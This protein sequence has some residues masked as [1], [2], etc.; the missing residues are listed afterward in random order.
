MKAYGYSSK[1][2]MAKG[3]LPLEEI[4]FWGQP[5]VLR[6]LAEFINLM[7]N[8]IECNPDFDH[9]HLRDSWEKWIED[10][11]DIIIVRPEKPDS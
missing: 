3:P 2:D 1:V 5:D 6:S 11:P 8:E 10:Y 7:A 4:S 9:R